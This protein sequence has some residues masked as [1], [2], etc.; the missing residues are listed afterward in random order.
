M[1]RKPG[2]KFFTAELVSLY[3][4]KYRLLILFT[5]MIFLGGITPFTSGET[6]VIF[7]AEQSENKES[8]PGTAVEEVGKDD[9]I[10]SSSPHMVSGSGPDLLSVPLMETGLGIVIQIPTPPPRIS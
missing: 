2:T 7:H 3:Q 8:K 4:L 6:P 5:G 1:W 9:E 10:F